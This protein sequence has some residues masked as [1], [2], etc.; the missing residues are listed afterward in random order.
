MMSKSDFENK[1]LVIV[2]LVGFFFNL[3]FG[4]IGVLCEHG[5][6]EQLLFYQVGNACAI[7]A[8]VMAGR[9]TGLRGQQVAA[10]AYILLGITHG[11][12]LAA[13]SRAG[14]NVDREASMAMPMIPALIFMFWCSL[15]PGWLK[16]LGLVPSALFALVV[17]DAHV[18][19][20]VLGWRLYFGYGTLQI[21]ELIWAIYLFLDWKKLEA[22]K[23]DGRQ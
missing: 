18:S 21:T 13:L 23:K 5:T 16:L 14:I 9:Y 7:S 2:V 6:T 12:S 17:V 1:S 15:Y 19:E 22:G 20:S 10:S 4:W 3:I 8:C 11:I